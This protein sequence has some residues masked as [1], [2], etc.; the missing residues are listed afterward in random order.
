MHIAIIGNGITGVTCA[1]YIRKLSDHKITIISAETEHHYS[2]TA[3]MYIY[4]GHMKYENTKPYEDHFWSKN[5]I[6]LKRG[7]VE[8]VDTDG[9]QLYFKG[10]DTM[11]YDKLVIACGSK[12]NKFGWPGQDLDGV[13]GLY[14]YQDLELLEKNTANHPN[15]AVIVGGGLIGIELAEMLHSRHI[16]VT[17]LIREGSF[18]NNVLPPG[19]SALVT[20]HIREHGFDLRT[21]VNLGEIVSDENGRA[22]AVIIKETGEKIDCQL[23]GLTAGVSPNIQFL[24]ESKIETQR[25]VLVNLHQETNIPDVYAAG[26]C[27]QFHEPVAGRRNLEQVW[28]TGKIQGQVV[29]KN[30][31]GEKAVYDPG[32]WFNSAKFLDIEYQTYGWVFSKLREGETDFYWEHSD[33]KQCLHFVWNEA[34]GQF[35][36]MNTFGIRL[37]HKVFDRFLRDKRDID[38]VI[39][40]LKAANFDPEFYKEIEGEVIAAYNK[41]TGKNLKVKGKRGIRAALALLGRG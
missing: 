33:G 11:A 8:N 21:N 37:R 34:S 6:N 10:G 24:K 2:R 38:Y 36:G 35:I 5:R 27:A 32:H 14:S 26:D 25:G 41:A 1:R 7:Y 13:Q 12:P 20:R 29:A 23:V 39:E 40:N 22:K 28:Y 18:W 31:C 17:I 30:I 3:L 9:K 19:E 4:M 15:R 16:P